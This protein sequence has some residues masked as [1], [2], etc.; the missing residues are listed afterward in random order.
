M[1]GRFHLVF[2]CL[3]DKPCSRMLG[4]LRDSVGEILLVRA[5]SPRAS[6]PSKIL[7]EFLSLTEGDLSVTALGHAGVKDA[8]KRVEGDTV[9]AG[10]LYLVGE[11]LKLIEEGAVSK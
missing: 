11:G 10:S 9:V 2:G 1:G 3:K 4:V 8:L 6:P 7:N 5:P